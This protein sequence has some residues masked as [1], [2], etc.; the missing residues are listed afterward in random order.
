MRKS[1]T[2]YLGKNAPGVPPKTKPD[3]TV[4]V[5]D[6]DLINLSTGRLNVRRDE[7]VLECRRAC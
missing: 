5:S 4:S 6:R 7:V 1:G 3:V 2:F